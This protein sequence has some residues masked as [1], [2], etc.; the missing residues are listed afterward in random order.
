MKILIIAPGIAPPWTEGRKN[1][2]RDLLPELHGRAPTHL[3]TTHLAAGRASPHSFSI[4]ATI[5]PVR[6]RGLQLLALERELPKLVDKVKPDVALHFPYG[7]FHGARG[8]LNRRSVM[9]IHR[10]SRRRQLPCLTI[11]YSMTQGSLR[12]LEQKVPLLA[13]APTFNWS[14]LVVNPGINSEHFP[15]ITHPV[16]NRSLLF[17]AGL[18][19]NNGRLLRNILFERGLIEIIEAGQ[20]LASHHFRLSIAIPL[21]RYPE[22]RAELESYLARLAPD[23]PARILTEASPR[24]LFARHSVYLFPYK[25]NLRVFIPTSVVEAMSAGIPVLLARLPM[26]SPLERH[27][28]VCSF[29]EA[30][31]PESL[32]EALLEMTLNWPAALERAERAIGYTRRY[33]N[34]G[35]AAEQ[36]WRIIAA[37]PVQTG[38]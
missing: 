29:Y 7:T 8:W 28:P 23:L 17:M 32:V 27:P 18:Q 36:I 5:L 13:A 3:L 34:V 31:N 37:L 12:Q 2:V 14:G 4:P 30:G 16:N 20:R 11:L 1:F 6:H 10:A 35:H 21:L 15:P 22:R 25:K 24:Q 9:A 19:E 33:W 38:K 26:L